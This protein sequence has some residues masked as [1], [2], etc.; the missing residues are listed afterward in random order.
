M[1][2]RHPLARVRGLGSAKSGTHHWWMQRV[3]SIALVPLAIW[4]IYAFLQ[5]ATGV[6]V[7][8]AAWM[9]NPCNAV[10]LIAFLG[11]SAYHSQLGV[12]VVVEDY[13]HCAKIKLALL[14]LNTLGTWF[15]FLVAVMAIA[16]LHFV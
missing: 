3:T 12:Q 16:K 6:S 13:V 2:F 15:A 7:D 8:I 1:Q 10:L 4:F 11:A 14:L 9:Q 5:M